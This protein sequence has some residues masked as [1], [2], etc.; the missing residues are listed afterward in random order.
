MKGKLIK[1]FLRLSVSAGFLSAVA[2]RFGFWDVNN[3][4]WGNMDNFF[5]YTQ[6]LN[7][8]IP[9]SLI[10]VVGW[11]STI[12]EFVFGIFLLAG[13]KTS[14]VA[15]GS[16]WLL[17]LFALAMTFS[18]GIKKPLDYSVFAASGGAFAIALIKEKF[19]EIDSLLSKNQKKAS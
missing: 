16:G 18:L 15:K 1:L 7:P 3:S 19:W 4:A 14:V 2:D 17:L 6:S 12:L 9:L 11:I 13:F 5:I 10:P 8:F